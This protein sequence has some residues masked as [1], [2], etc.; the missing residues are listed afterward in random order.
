MKKADALEV[1]STMGKTYLNPTTGTFV[2]EPQELKIEDRAV[3]YLNSLLTGCV[4]CGMM[5]EYNTL[6]EL[7]PDPET[8]DVLQ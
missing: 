8:K 5:D 2:W 1:S 7:L 4:R 3:C 6:L